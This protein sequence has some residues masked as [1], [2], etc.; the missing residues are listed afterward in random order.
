MGAGGW[1]ISA[2]QF[3]SIGLSSSQE[4]QGTSAPPWDTS[5]SSDLCVPPAVSHTFPL[6]TLFVLH[7]MV[8]PKC[9]FSEGWQAGWW[10]AV[11]SL[12]SWLEKPVPSTG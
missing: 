7:F 9:P 2:Q 1:L 6:P 4:L 10:P 12:W 8:S 5:S 11:G 3:L